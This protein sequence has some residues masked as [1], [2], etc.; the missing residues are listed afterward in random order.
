MEQLSYHCAPTPHPRE[1]S[2]HHSPVSASPEEHRRGGNNKLRA[3][4]G[5]AQ[6]QCPGMT[7]IMISQQQQLH[8]PLPDHGHGCLE[9]LNVDAGVEHFVIA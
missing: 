2:A 5:K 7:L 3:V 9:L 8:I 6:P 1:V 4:S